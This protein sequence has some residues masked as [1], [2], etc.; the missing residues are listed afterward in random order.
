MIGIGVLQCRGDGGSYRL[1]PDITTQIALNRNE[2]TG[3]ELIICRGALKNY[4]LALLYSVLLSNALRVNI[5]VFY[6]SVLHSMMVPLMCFMLVTGRSNCIWLVIDSRPKPLR[7]HNWLSLSNGAFAISRVPLCVSFSTHIHT[8]SI[9]GASHWSSGIS[10]I[11]VCNSRC[12]SVNPEYTSLSQQPQLPCFFL[13][14]L[15]GFYKV[16][17]H[18]CSCNNIFVFCY[19]YKCHPVKRFWWREVV[20]SQLIRS[21]GGG[22]LISPSAPENRM[23]MDCHDDTVGVL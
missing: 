22:A 14:S 8:Q 2:L 15:P 1:D 13:P 11:V 18:S 17:L 12:P 4:T 20:R 10:V 16:R 6:L 21:P 3:A 19:L 23:Q 9:Y 7:A 5:V